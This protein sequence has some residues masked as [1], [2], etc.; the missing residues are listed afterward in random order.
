MKKFIKKFVPILS[1]FLLGLVIAPI[2][3]VEAQTFITRIY[4]VPDGVYYNVD[5][6]EMRQAMNVIWPAGSKHTLFVDSP[7]QDFATPKT[8]YIFTGWV[9]GDN[10][11]PG[12]PVVV[13]ADP[14]NTE[15]HAVFQIQYAISVA[16]FSCPS[17]PC[18]GP[19][20]VYVNGTPV[21][22]DQ[23][24][25]VSPGSSVT[26]QAVPSDGYVFTGWAPGPGQ[27]IQGFQ[28]FV[29]VNQPVTVHPIF[30]SARH[31]NLATSPADLK[32]LA[33]GAAVLTPATLQWGF[34][35]SHSLAPLSPQQDINGKWWMFSSWSDGGAAVRTYQVDS[36]FTDANLTANYVPAA[37]VTLLTSPL[38]LKLVVD[39][40]DNWPSYNFNWGVGETH[41]IE[42]PPQQTDSQ[43]RVWSFSEWSNGGS[44]AQDFTVPDEAGSNGGVRLTATYQAFGRLTL[45][46]SVPV[47]LN[48][49]GNDCATPCDIQHPQGTQ[50]HVSAPGS[51]PL[52]DNSR[53]DFL[54]WSDS[55]TGDLTVTLG[56]NPQTMS[57][58]F[59]VMNRLTAISDPPDGVS[60]TM[61][62]ASSD[63]F[64]DSQLSVSVTATPLAGFR[65][66][67]WSGDLSGSSPN[68]TLN[69]N[70]PRSIRAMLD[71]V[72]YIAPAGVGNAAGSTPQSAVAPG[73]II[74][75]FGANLANSTAV[76]PTSPMVQT[77]GGATVQVGDRMLPLYFV[78]ST[79][80]NAQLPPDLPSGPQTLTV[81]P[82]GK[83]QVR[84]DFTV[85]ADAPG[86]F[87]QLI[88]GQIFAL[89]LHEDGSAV[90]TDSPA[91]RGELLTLYGTGF[92]ASNPGRPEGVAIPSSPAFRIVDPVDVQ[93]GSATLQP[94]NSFAMPG[95]VGLDIVQFRLSDGAP[96]A[97]NAPLQVSVNGQLSNTV[98][99]PVQ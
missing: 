88:G 74:S 28:N 96:T 48:V 75:I 50:V 22:S 32:V 17:T 57:A 45:T 87:G 11:L 13:T 24:I 40:R 66:R 62:P 14:S 89:A 39:G 82:D 35:T 2:G 85:A 81:S 4:T 20:T 98:L 34:N 64:Y 77:L 43:G 29:T 61:Q 8:K 71:S 79:Q 37:T 15:F 10:S 80:I 52:G 30:Q 21:T 91:R 97:Q 12:N 76:G 54:G 9:T 7:E 59:H 73:S 18:Q 60:W 23:D 68:G 38:G 49:D 67:Q 44:A 53:A 42:A 84:A 95:S 3:R 26:L 93:V 19:G 92:G 33:D 72:P 83:T 31:I 25:Y 94:Q 78:S 55:S 70:A 5:G 41:H 69:M 36:T 47:T 99:L 1:L 58:N 63:G 56:A 16:F 86:V 46:S 65:F 51:V 90:T 27:V 6:Q